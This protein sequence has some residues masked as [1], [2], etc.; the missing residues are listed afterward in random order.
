MEQLAGYSVA[1][2]HASSL[3]SRRQLSRK[4]NYT[5]I[6]TVDITV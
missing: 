4:I 6:Y 5:V 2:E 1:E 3:Y